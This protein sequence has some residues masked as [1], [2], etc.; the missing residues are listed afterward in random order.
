MKYIVYISNAEHY[1]SIRE[2]LFALSG[3]WNQAKEEN[4][5][6][7]ITGILI[8]KNEQFLQFIEGPDENID[9]LIEKI[10]RDQRH[11]NVNILFEGSS[12]V[13]AFPKFSMALYNSRNDTLPI[14]LVKQYLKN[15]QGTSQHDLR[16]LD[17]FS[18]VSNY[19]A[20]K[21]DD[22]DFSHC[23]L[24]LSVWPNFTNIKPS[25]EV[26]DLCVVLINSKKHFN[27]LLLLTN[28]QEKH[29]L[30]RRLNQ[31][32]RAGVLDVQQSNAEYKALNKSVDEQQQNSFHLHMR[33]FLAKVLA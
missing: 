14:H 18:V 29:Q 19:H 28:L 11:F 10:K 4:V 5:K 9:E 30:N 16:V 1:E 6:H 20:V 33:A 2:T 15:Q 22:Q 17:E 31:L 12:K 21:E 26:V 3:V 13:R 23:Y 25:P 32:Y 24:Q 7:D 27:E 8:Y